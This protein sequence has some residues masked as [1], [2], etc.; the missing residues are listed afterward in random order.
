MHGVAAARRSVAGDG[1]TAAGG[2]TAA[3]GPAVGGTRDSTGAGSSGRR[4]SK[5]HRCE[6][7]V[8]RFKS[9]YPSF[10][11]RVALVFKASTHRFSSE[12]PSF[13]SEN[14]SIL[15]EIIHRSEAK[16]GAPGGRTPL[17][18]PLSGRVR[19]LWLRPLPPRA[20]PPRQSSG[21]RAP[22]PFGPS[23]GR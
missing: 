7:I 21:G 12:C 22:L 19:N 17:S 2:S 8:H 10:L 6:V 15:S 16:A 11:K 23:Q 1:V 5:F 18:I 9:E 13:S 3:T 20:P 14:P 4:T